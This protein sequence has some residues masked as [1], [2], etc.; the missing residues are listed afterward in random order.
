MLEEGSTVFCCLQDSVCMCVYLCVA[1]GGLKHSLLSHRPQK[2]LNTGSQT[3]QRSHA[4][5]TTVPSFP[6]AFSIRT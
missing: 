6:T 3:A 5:H 1:R 2:T 4:S